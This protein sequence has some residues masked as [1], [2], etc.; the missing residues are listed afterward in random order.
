MII[1]IYCH[2]NDN[3]INFSSNYLKKNCQG[4]IIAFDVGIKRI[5]VATCDETRNFYSPKTIIQ[6]KNINE[7]LLKIKELIL[8]N[9][10][11]FVVIGLPLNPNLSHN[12]ISL[13]ILD[14]AQNLNN[15]LQNEMIIF[16]TDESFSS[17]SARMTQKKHCNKNKFYDDI[18]ASIILEGF[19]N[20]YCRQ[21]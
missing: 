1:E 10:A 16:L 5:G 15:F 3:I 7:D 6:R 17:F 18:A 19:V 8:E 2:N 20:E 9:K 11:Q 13:K 12:Q 21:K 4:K 14:F